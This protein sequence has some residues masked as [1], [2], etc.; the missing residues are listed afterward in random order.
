MYTKNRTVAQ[1][2]TCI[3]L[4]RTILK[5]LETQS[6]NKITVNKLC[7]AAP[8]SRAAF[9][10][11]Y[12]DKYQLLRSALEHKKPELFGDGIGD[13]NRD[14]LLSAVRNIRHHGSAFKNMLVGDRN[15]ELFAMFSRIFV[16]AIAEKLE[17]SQEKLSMPSNFLS[18]YAAG[19]CS[20]L[21]LWWIT[22]NYA[23]SEEELT[24]RLLELLSRVLR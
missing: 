19:G 17:A 16:D 1:N 20:Y 7:D 9:Y 21:V 10:S 6:F 24:D 2:R 5:L 15:H 18:V 11:H 8:V 3:L 13:L 22:E 23:V 12:D 4:E 14:T